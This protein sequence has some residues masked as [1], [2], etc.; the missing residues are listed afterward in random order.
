[1]DFAPWQL[2]AGNK[3]ILKCHMHTSWENWLVQNSGQ[4]PWMQTDKRITIKVICQEV[5]QK[6]VPEIPA[7]QQSRLSEVVHRN[8]HICCMLCKCLN[9]LD[10]G[11]VMWYPSPRALPSKARPELVKC[12]H[13]AHDDSFIN[14]QRCAALWKYGGKHLVN[15]KQLL[16]EIRSYTKYIT[17][18][19]ISKWNCTGHTMCRVNYSKYQ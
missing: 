14:H 13:K 2:E 7:S 6:R 15:N 12:T 3:T 18:T 5:D 1:M 8:L 11:Y 19:S 16:L 9:E 4:L 10:R 17:V